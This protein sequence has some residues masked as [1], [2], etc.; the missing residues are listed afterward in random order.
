VGLYERWYT[1]QRQ[2]LHLLTYGQDFGITG[3]AYLATTL[4]VQGY[5]DQAL[6]CHDAAVSAAQ[7]AG[8]PFTHVRCLIAAMPVRR[9]RREAPA[10][11]HEIEVAAALATEHRFPDLLAQAQA[12]HGWALCM[13]GHSD[14]GLAELHRGLEAL[15]QRGVDLLLLQDLCLLAEVHM[16][17]GQTEEGLAAVANGVAIIG[18]MGHS[19]YLA[20]LHRLRGELLLEQDAAEAEGCFRQALAVAREQGAHALELRAALSL[21]RLW[22]RQGKTAEAHALLAECY[23]WFTEGFETADLQA[24]RAFLEVLADTPLSPQG[25][26]A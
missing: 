5:V 12:H 24:A 23:S 21:S 16:I 26:A 17:L 2:R 1:P 3:L 25:G 7:E 9:V 22:Q 18:R 15:S 20:E 8:H 19:V 4:A 14:E 6:A 11:Q 10:A 13:Q